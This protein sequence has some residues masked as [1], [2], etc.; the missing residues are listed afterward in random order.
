MSATL[1]VSIDVAR[2]GLGSHVPP[3]FLEIIVI[4]ALRG[5]T[6]NKI[7]LFAYNQTF[8]PPPN[9]WTPTN[10]WAGYASDCRAGCQ[11][12]ERIALLLVFVV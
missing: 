10:F 3:K 12:Y 6:T 7:V 2:A 1:T 11:T 5:G 8:W 4:C 9:L